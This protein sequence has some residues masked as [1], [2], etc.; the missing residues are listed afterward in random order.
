MRAHRSRYHSSMIGDPYPHANAGSLCTVAMEIISPCSFTASRLSCVTLYSCLSSH[1][2]DAVCFLFSVV[3][4]PFKSYILFACARHRLHL[5]GP[6]QRQ[7][8]TGDFK[9]KLRHWLNCSNA[10]MYIMLLLHFYLL[11][12][13]LCAL[14]KS[15]PHSQLHFSQPILSKTK[16]ALISSGIRIGRRHC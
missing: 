7:L 9:V 12:K 4:L 6:H 13:S 15:A 3:S 11:I 16:Y 10:F 5:M 8:Q 14:G 2:R 1:W